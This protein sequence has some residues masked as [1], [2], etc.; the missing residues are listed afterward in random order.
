MTLYTKFALV[1]IFL[2]IVA[3]GLGEN[4]YITQR[5]VDLLMVIGS[6]LITIPFT[7]FIFLDIVSFIFKSIVNYFRKIKN[8]FTE[9]LKN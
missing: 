7:I 6:S 3:T 8:S 9:G 4:D 5:L 1:G 2:I